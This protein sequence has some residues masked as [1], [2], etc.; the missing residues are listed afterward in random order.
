MYNTGLLDVIDSRSLQSSLRRA[1]IV[2]ATAG[3]FACTL[4][5]ARASSIQFLD[6]FKNVVNLQTANGNS[7]TAN[8][9]F[10]SAELNSSV[11]NAYSSVTMTYPGPSSPLNIPQS[12]P[13]VY[14]YQSAS[15]ATKADM[16]AAFPAGTYLFTAS[17]QL[18]R[19]ILPVSSTPLT[20]MPRAFR[21]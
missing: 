14:H 1:L 21:F 10:Y 4:P 17:P 12:T 11:A 16:D 13:T 15:L 9:A 19:P 3:L 18:A 5:T 6:S 8:G 20:I 2:T 7:L